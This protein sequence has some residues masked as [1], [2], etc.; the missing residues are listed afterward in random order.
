MEHG[1]CDI[2]YLDR[3]AKDEHVK[4]ENIASSSIVA[5]SANPGVPDYFDLPRPRMG[6]VRSNVE[7]ILSAFNEVHICSTGAASLKIVSKL[8]DSSVAQCP[9]IMLID[10]P[11]DEDLRLRRISREPRTPSPT[12]VYAHHAENDIYGVDLL[13]HISSQIQQRSMS[14]LVIPIVV[15]SGQSRDRSSASSLISPAVHGAQMLPDTVRLSRY[16]DAGAVDVLSSP[17]SKDHMQRVGVHAY[18]IYKE[19]MREE[20]KFLAVKKNRK[21]SWVGVDDTKPFA[22][23]REAMVSNLMLGIC[24][25]E[26]VDDK[27]DPNDLQVDEERKPVVAEAIGRWSFSAHEFSDDELTYGA[28]LMLQHA[29]AMPGLEAYNMTDDELI[30]FLLASRKAYNDFVLYHNFRHVADVLQALFVF[31][32]RIGALPPYPTGTTSEPTP[33]KSPIASLIEP[34]QALTL[35]I[36]AIGHDVGHPGVNNAF[37]VALNAPLAQLY[38]DR[39]VLE[40]FHCAAYSQILRRYWP[41]AFKD[42]SMR[43]LMI[44]TILATDMG[45]HFQYMYDLGNLQEKLAHTGN[46]LLGWDP[47]EVEKARSLACGLL[48]KCADISNVARVFDVAKEWTRILIDEFSNQGTMEEELQMPTTLFGGP[49][50]RDNIVKMGQ[51]QIGFINVFAQALFGEV[52]NILPSMQFT[53]DELATNRKVWERK[54]QEEKDKQTAAAAY[55][56]SPGSGYDGMNS[57]MTRSTADLP[58]P[59]TSSPA[60]PKDNS[61][62]NASTSNAIADALPERLSTVS[63][64]SRHSSAGS[65]PPFVPA[66]TSSRRSSVGLQTADSEVTS[67]RS[68]GGGF[69][70]APPF[71][72][73]DCATLHDPSTDNSLE[74]L[75]ALRKYDVK[76]SSAGDES[77]LATSHPSLQTIN[78]SISARQTH[79]AAASE[80]LAAQSESLL[81]VA[82]S[83]DGQPL[84]VQAPAMPLPPKIPEEDDSRTRRS[85]PLAHRSKSD[86]NLSRHAQHQQQPNGTY[87]TVQVRPNRSSAGSASPTTSTAAQASRDSVFKGETNRLFLKSVSSGGSSSQVTGGSEKGPE[88]H[89]HQDGGYAVKAATTRSNRLGLAKKFPFFKRIAKGERT[90]NGDGTGEEV[91][92]TA[93]AEAR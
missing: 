6:E 37:L 83:D 64:S 85:F 20:S 48:I 50:E 31:L 49:P 28:L 15:L 26:R 87:H 68:S 53:V 34:F 86:V 69:P 22:Y 55:L 74:K 90:V 59:S 21:L 52:T 25:P 2:V 3:K 75:A 12:F 19:H 91:G 23:L 72:P 30:I 35:L 93:A 17:L 76:D 92:V 27:I 40:S 18:R 58:R 70:A 36:A 38:N 57:P 77:M 11:Y 1:A 51:S 41:V 79:A 5:S 4:R 29:L 54:I 67:Q 42:V 81:T 39:S 46:S 71:N 84:A 78:G 63:T 44:N 8:H 60:S 80:N 61:N 82:A 24:N 56:K 10:V 45:L 88:H 16:L 73:V 14:R 9:I 47:K 7:T 13:F 62:S 66:A 33:L 65:P 43:N 32:V 89:H